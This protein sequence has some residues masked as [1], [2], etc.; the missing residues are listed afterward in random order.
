MKKIITTLIIVIFSANAFAQQTISSDFAGQNAW[1]PASHPGN[2]NLGGKLNLHWDD[3]KSS[4]TRFVRVGG[5]AYDKWLKNPSDFNQFIS[6][7]L[8]RN[9]IPIVQL[10]YFK[11]PTTVYTDPDEA[12]NDA[13]VIVLYI[14]KV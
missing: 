10:S 8:S 4:E 7:I 14:R 2:S 13:L 11:T 6:D 5:I 1:M 12:A 3:I 9:M